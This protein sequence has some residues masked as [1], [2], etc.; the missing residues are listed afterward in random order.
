MAGQGFFKSLGGGHLGP[1]ATVFASQMQVNPCKDT[2]FSLPNA[3]LLVGVLIDAMEYNL[4]A[5]YRPLARSTLNN[6]IRVSKEIDCLGRMLQLNIRVRHRSV[7]ALHP[8]TL[9]AL[10]MLSVPAES[11]LDPCSEVVTLMTYIAVVHRLSSYVGARAV[12]DLV[13]DFNRIIPRKL[14]P[15]V[16]TKVPGVGPRAGTRCKAGDE[17]RPARLECT[18]ELGIPPHMVYFNS[19]RQYRGRPANSTPGLFS[20]PF[21]LPEA[22]THVSR[23]TLS[24]KLCEWGTLPPPQPQ[25]LWPNTPVHLHLATPVTHRLRRRPRREMALMVVKA[26]IPTFVLTPSPVDSFALMANPRASSPNPYRIIEEPNPNGPG[27]QVS[28]QLAR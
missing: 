18:G 6:V 26:P 2:N 25:L 9:K 27:E 8:F 21:Q 13:R 11:L 15:S 23:H 4:C 22:Y 7:H 14:D 17:V 3:N 12:Y 24:Q 1:R 20:A 28:S 19:P 16:V 5:R 10:L